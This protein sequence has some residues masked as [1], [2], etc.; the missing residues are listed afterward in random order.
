MHC[1]PDLFQVIGALHTASGFT[2]GLHCGQKQG[3]QNA[4]DGDDDEKF[5]EGETVFNEIFIFR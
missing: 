5:D 4:D 3:N 2:G 1:Q